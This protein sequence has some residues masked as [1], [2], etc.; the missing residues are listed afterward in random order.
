MEGTYYI[1][2]Y[3]HIYHICA[4]NKKTRALQNTMQPCSI[5]FVCYFF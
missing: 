5:L 4:V 3:T 1:P 2:I